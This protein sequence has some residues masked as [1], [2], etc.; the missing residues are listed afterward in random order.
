MIKI[1][2][3]D[4]KKLR[5]ITGAGMMDC[6]NALT[7]ATGDIELAIDNLRKRGQ[8]LSAKRADRD[9]KEGV[10][11]ALVN[12]AKDSGI[13]IKLSSET[14][15]VAKNEDFINLAKKIAQLTLEN[16][17]DSKEDLLNIN[18]NDS[19]TIGEKITEQVGVIGEKI[20]VAEYQKI[21]A[22]LVV[23]YIHMGYRAG[24]LTGLSKNGSDDIEQVG[25]DVAMQIAAMRPIALNQD[26]VDQSVI[27]KEIQ[28]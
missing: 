20:E 7:E 15:F 14:D 8:K 13:I 3:K 17:P 10:V 21:T 24:V 5:D 25:K 1:S 22:G 23:P 9:A 19:L 11:M 12:D 26:G 16:M 27:E 4:V 6:K 18:F 2:A 28:I